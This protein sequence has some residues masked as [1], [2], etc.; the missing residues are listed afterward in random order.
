MK[1]SMKDNRVLCIAPSEWNP[2]VDAISGIASGI[3]P[4]ANV[5]IGIHRE[6]L[7]DEEMQL[8]VLKNRSL[9]ENFRPLPD[10]MFEDGSRRD[11]KTS[12]NIKDE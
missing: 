4:I 6:P 10:F 11:L 12:K 7:S 2:S 1:E 8:M 3:E 9:P 5:M